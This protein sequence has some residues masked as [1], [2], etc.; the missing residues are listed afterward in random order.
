MSQCKPIKTLMVELL[1]G[2]MSG[3]MSGQLS[4][5]PSDASGDK[6]QAQARIDS[7][8]ATCSVCAREYQVLQGIYRETTEQEREVGV[9]MESINWDD[10]AQFISQ[11]ARFRSKSRTAP[12]RWSPVGFL[13]SGGFKL[14]VPTM[15][16]VFFLGIWLGYILFYSTPRPLGDGVNEVRPQSTFSLARLES[17]LERKE[18]S[19]YFKQAHVLL[20]DLMRPCGNDDEAA[21][22]QQENMPLVKILLKKNRYLSTDLDDPNLLSSRSLLKKIEWL[23]YEISTSEGPMDCKRLHHLQD[24]IEQE[25]LLM[26][27]RLVSKD[28]AYG[29]I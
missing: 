15:A 7:H 2:E 1:S 12:S 14:A 17:T 5:V 22:L 10:N 3:E 20:A 28:V 23:L 24:Y 8:I 21:R 18:V 4:G 26:K 9:L 16:V 19:G 6:K 27:L 13:T 11:R 29:E 25:R